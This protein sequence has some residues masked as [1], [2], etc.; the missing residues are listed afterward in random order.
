MSPMD[1]DAR[2]P[3]R[4]SRILLVSAL[5]LALL[6]GSAACSARPTPTTPEPSTAQTSVAPPP[7]PQLSGPNAMTPAVSAASSSAGP[8][9]VPSATSA[10]SA[11]ADSSPATVSTLPS[12]G[13]VGVNAPSCH[14]TDRPVV[15]LHGTFSTVAANFS[16]MAPALMTAGRCVYGINYG[17]SGVGPI[18][19]SAGEVARFI[20]TVRELTGATK[21]DVV[22]Y[23][24]GGLVLR[25]A[26]RFNGL[27][28]QVGTAVLLAPSWNGTTSLLAGTLPA[29][30]CPA[31]ADQV[32]SSPLL[33][34]LAVGGD[35][36]GS[37]HYAE[38]STRGDTVVTPISSQVP[39]GPADRVRS[40]VV[41]KQ[42]P[43]LHTDHVQ[44]PAVP[45]VI[46]W[47]LSA[48]TTGGRPPA[49]AFTC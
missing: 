28:Q 35:L 9:T 2:A 32:A 39:T 33:K 29:S 19:T 16:V 13:L 24:Q 3:R 8:S 44:L 34:R 15:L 20:K 42:C 47:T 36:D 38:L 43:N 10:S 21:V 11:A 4:L 26:L 23:S 25:T 27:A 30:L 12:V 5:H 48:L 31:C 7:T 49:G 18:A 6:A 40:I 46:A 41:E 37:V 17:N 22:G 14:S 1:R 45:G